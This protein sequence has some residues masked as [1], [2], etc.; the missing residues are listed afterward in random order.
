MSFFL[1]IINVKKYVIAS[2][3]KVSMSGLQMEIEL[4]S[5][6]WTLERLANSL[7]TKVVRILHFIRI[8]NLNKKAVPQRD[9]HTHTPFKTQVL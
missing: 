7:G 6:R 8:F 9:T 4:I 1:G 5:W 3:G 2:V